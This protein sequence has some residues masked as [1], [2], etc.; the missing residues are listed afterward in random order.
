MAGAIKDAVVT[1]VSASGTV[2]GKVEKTGGLV[3]HLR[4]ATITKSS[5]S[6]TVNGNHR[7]GGLVGGL[8]GNSLLKEVFAT[9]KVTASGT[10]T[11][12]LVG[13]S[14]GGSKVIDCYARG[15]VEGLNTV[16][17]SWL[18]DRLLQKFPELFSGLR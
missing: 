15:N 10:E 12:G 4:G 14:K 8:D 5:S 13:N 11:G 16:G 9:G 6:A 17:G 2:T 18:P 3:G 7:T 1:N